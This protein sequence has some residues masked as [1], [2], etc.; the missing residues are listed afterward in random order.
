VPAGS[1]RIRSGVQSRD[2]FD[3][4]EEAFQAARAANPRPPDSE[5]RHRVTNNLMQLPD[6]KWTFRYDKA[7]RAPDRPLP[8]PD[9][10]QTWALLPKIDCPTL[11]IRGAESDVLG[12]DTAERMVRDI[13]DCRMIEVPNSGHSVPARQPHRLLGDRAAVFVS[14]APIAQ[15]SSRAGDKGAPPSRLRPHTPLHRIR[16][17]VGDADFNSS[18]ILG[19]IA[20][21]YR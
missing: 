20:R 10:S 21:A 12:R 1:D 7:L 11:L 5:L 15:P 6:G 19:L 3:A 9:P 16:R 2:V 8:R 18:R 4:P 13:P 14:G 17:A